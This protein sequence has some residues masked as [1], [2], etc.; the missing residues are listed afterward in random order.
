MKMDG[1]FFLLLTILLASADLRILL[2]SRFCDN[3]LRDSM[4]FASLRKSFHT[5]CK[6]MRSSYLSSPPLLYLSLR[7]TMISI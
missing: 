6:G 2:N 7:I 1:G 5:C 4:H 3:P